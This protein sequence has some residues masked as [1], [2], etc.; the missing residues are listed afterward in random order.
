MRAGP[1]MALDSE[2][3]ERWQ[4]NLLALLNEPKLA[5]FVRWRMGLNGHVAPGEEILSISPHQVTVPV[6]G[7]LRTCFM[8]QPA[9]QRSL[10]R[11]FRP[12]LWGMHA[13]D[14][15]LPDRVSQ[16]WV[17]SLIRPLRPAFEGFGLATLTAYP[18]AGAG[19][20]NTT[21]DGYAGPS[22]VTS[23]TFSSIRAA[24]A[25]YADAATTVAY[26]GLQ[27]SSTADQF[28][29]LYRGYVSFAT[30]AL[31]AA[32]IISSAVVSLWGLAFFANLGA[33]ALDVVQSTQASANAVVTGDFSR[34]GSTSFGSIASGSFATGQY[35]AISLNA[36]G[37][38]AIAKTGVTEFAF[39]L[40]W[41]VAAAFG[42]LWASSAV[43]QFGWYAADYSSGVDAPK[44]VVTYT[45]PTLAMRRE[46]SGLGTRMGSRQLQG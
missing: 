17:Q 38:A 37:I 26:A 14:W 32:A 28:N 6:R 39:L 12:I 34:V 41:D 42:G 33:N 29:C 36:S 19:G 11:G 2:K 21:C 35:N 25:T 45:A 1:W 20:G 46:L 40:D 7:G 44:L 3:F 10:Y 18:Q 5:R 9:L 30:S 13:Y 43:T 16:R 15:A 23:Q 24:T 31:G 8:P 4:P 27:A 22:Y